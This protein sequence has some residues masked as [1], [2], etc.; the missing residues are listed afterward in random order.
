MPKIHK[1]PVCDLRFSDA[2]HDTYELHEAC[3]DGLVEKISDLHAIRTLADLVEDE[4]RA[5][6]LDAADEIEQDG[7]MG[8]V[9]R[10]RELTDLLTS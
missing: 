8:D 7:N 1:C 2:D 5:A 9:H 3:F 10:L 4:V 6:L